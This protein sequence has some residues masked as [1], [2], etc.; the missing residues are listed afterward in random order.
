VARLRRLVGEPGTDT[1]NDRQLEEYLDR[2]ESV[3]AAA[4]E[5]WREKAARYADLVDVTE[6]S[7]SRRLSQL[8]T[9]ARDMAKHFEETV[10]AV[11]VT[12]EG[13]PRSR[14]IVRG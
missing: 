6:G 12:I 13:R 5:V 14:P 7:S 10:T 8:V 2:S 3:E 9:Q 4:A 1:Y 11:E